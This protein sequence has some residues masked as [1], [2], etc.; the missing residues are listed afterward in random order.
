MR[1]KNLSIIQRLEPI[2]ANPLPILTHG[3]PNDHHLQQ[4]CLNIST[5]KIR[6]IKAAIEII[7]KSAALHGT[8]SL[9]AN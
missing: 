2:A 9:A 3:G 7:K 4:A 6:R 1:V 5:L 8:Y